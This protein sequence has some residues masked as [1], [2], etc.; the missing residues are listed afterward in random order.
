MKLKLE[1]YRG[2]QEEFGSLSLLEKRQYIIQTEQEDTMWY[3]RTIAKIQCIGF[4]IG[5]LIGLIFLMSIASK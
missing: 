4:I 2:T 5:A 1:N 3:Q